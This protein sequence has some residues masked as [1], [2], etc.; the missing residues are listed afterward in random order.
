[1]SGPQETII[2]KIRSLLRLGANG[3]GATK[4]E[5]ELAM[6]RAHALMTKHQIQIAQLDTEP[7]TVTHEDVSTYRSDR[8]CRVAL[9]ASL[10]QQFMGVKVI[11]SYGEITLVG[12]PD[13]IAYAKHSFGFLMESF[14]REW[15]RYH[16]RNYFACRRSFYRGLAD[17]LA[18]SLTTAKRAALDETAPHEAD[19]WAIAITN[20]Q[21]EA[22]I[23][24]RKHFCITG[25]RRIS[26]SV[27]ADDYFAGEEAGKTIT[28]HRPLTEGAP[29][30]A[31][32]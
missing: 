20:N 15:A 30:R 4:A 18:A 5:A 29:C 6:E 31:V 8:F 2:S 10:I 19:Q 1:M 22:E 26:R 32:A 9:I 14:N 23:Y 27:D 13:N 25:V 21:R 11:Q 12:T 28:V 24:C 7:E 16:K 3:S 17:G